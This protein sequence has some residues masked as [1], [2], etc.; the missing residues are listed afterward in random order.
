[1]CVR[2]SDVQGLRLSVFAGCALKTRHHD[3]NSTCHQTQ[4]AYF[5]APFQAEVLGCL[6]SGNYAYEDGDRE[7]QFVHVVFQ[8]Y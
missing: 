2:T 4:H 1:M 6:P 7:D 5:P 3:L 8:V